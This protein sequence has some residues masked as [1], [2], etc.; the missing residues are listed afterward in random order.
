MSRMPQEQIPSGSALVARL[1]SPV[2]E[3]ERSGSRRRGSQEEVSGAGRYAKCPRSFLFFS[4]EIT[5]LL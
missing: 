2:S 1:D 3:C 4:S 5:L